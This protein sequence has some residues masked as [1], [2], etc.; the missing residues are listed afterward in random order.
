MG[1]TVIPIKAVALATIVKR[2][3][4]RQEE[5][6]N[7]ERIETIQTTVGIHSLGERQ[8]RFIVTQTPVIIGCPFDMALCHI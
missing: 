1:A 2:F 5:F 8:K 6:K 3:G 7:R 4:K